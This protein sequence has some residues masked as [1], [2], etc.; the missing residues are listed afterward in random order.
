[1]VHS[2]AALGWAGRARV[3]TL[4]DHCPFG[5]LVSSRSPLAQ[6]GHSRHVSSLWLRFGARYAGTGVVRQCVGV[7]AHA[8]SGVTIAISAKNR[9]PCG[10]PGG[11]S[12]GSSGGAGGL[13]RSGGLACGLEERPGGMVAARRRRVHGLGRVRRILAVDAHENPGE[14]LHRCEQA[15]VARVGL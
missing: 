13:S 1:M 3:A 11:Q 14:R 10:P 4:L 12:H 5:C 2:D 8:T 9:G 6:L 15:G 7:P